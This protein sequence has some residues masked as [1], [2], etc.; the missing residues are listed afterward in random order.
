MLLFLDSDLGLGYFDGHVSLVA[1]HLRSTAF[2]CQF[3]HKATR[4]T[5]GRA[6]AFRVRFPSS[7]LYPLVDA[8]THRRPRRIFLSREVVSLDQPDLAFEALS[9]V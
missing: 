8:K 2:L 5:H 9:Y 3:T 1:L 4:T 7:G 6:T